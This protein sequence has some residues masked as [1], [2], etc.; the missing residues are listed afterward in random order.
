MVRGGRE[1]IIGMQ[2]DP[3]F[4]PLLMFGLG[5]IFVEVMKD[6]AFRISPI[7]DLDAREMVRSIRGFPILQGVRG[8]APA[9]LA[10]IEEAI[11]RL[12]QLV[13]DHP[14][15]ASFDVNPFLAFEE[16]RRSLAVD[17]RMSIVPP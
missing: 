13:L 15:I 8:A 7:T 4:G 6:V 10:A 5:G 16:G 14:E 2:L 3:S 1:T 17:A 11:L 9:D 12:S